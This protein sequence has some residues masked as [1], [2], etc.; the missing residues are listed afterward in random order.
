MACLALAWSAPNAARAEGPAVN[1]S[2]EINS[3]YIYHGFTYNDGFVFQPSLDVSAAWYGLNV[4]AN[5]DIRD[6]GGLLQKG[7][8]SEVDLS[9]YVFWNVG[10]WKLS[11]SYSEYLYPHL[12]TTNGA[13]PG[14]R[15]IIVSIKRS[16]TK[17]L[18]A[19]VK[20]QY[21]IDEIG[22]YY[23]R[24][25]LDYAFKPAENLELGLFGSVGYVG[26]DI[27][28]L[29]Y[30]GVKGGF[31]EYNIKTS[32]AYTIRKG[33]TLKANLGYTDALDKDVL[34]YTDVNTYG[35]ISLSTDL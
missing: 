16:I 17:G 1:V 12:A 27:A 11:L 5:M 8:F 33:L 20:L 34:P 25:A 24:L 2:A 30:G 22:D 29:A 4:W 6:Y 3:A 32:V 31:N 18:T 13:V 35:G 28:T 7:E 15:D 21:E 26:D 10:G 14:N 9:P 23:A 19:E